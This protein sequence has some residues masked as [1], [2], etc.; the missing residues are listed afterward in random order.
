M[1][2]GKSVFPSGLRSSKMVGNQD[3]RPMTWIKLKLYY[4]K[5]QAF[6][7]ELQKKGTDALSFMF[8]IR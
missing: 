4:I 5:I 2:L 1:H 6:Q 8:H 7:W 3:V